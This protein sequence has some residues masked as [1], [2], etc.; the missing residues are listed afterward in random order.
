MT[1]KN[2]SRRN[3]GTTAFA[4]SLRHGDN[5]AE[6]IIWTHLKARRLGGYKFVRQFPVGP[7]FADF[8]CRAQKLAVEIDGSQHVDSDKDKVRDQYFLE[9]GYSVARFWSSS[10]IANPQSVC[11]TLLAILEG[12]ISEDV[13]APD[14]RVL[15]ARQKSA[16]VAGPPSPS[17]EEA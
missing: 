17:R 16:F 5:M 13:T 1:E 8:L 7:Y 4:R 3:A 10:A 12:Q 11:E 14:L 9:A 2:R 15:F 6:A